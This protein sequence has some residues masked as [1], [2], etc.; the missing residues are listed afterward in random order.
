MSKMSQISAEMDEQNIP[1]E[2][3][4]TLIDRVSEGM[5]A[6]ERKIDNPTQNTNQPTRE[7]K[8][9]DIARKI[10]RFAENTHNVV[11]MDGKVYVKVG[12][13]QY[14]ADLLGITPKFSF[15]PESTSTEVWCS[16]TLKDEKG[17]VITTTVMY[18]DKREKFLCDK[19]DFAVLGTAQTR[20]FTRA[21]KNIYGFVVEMIGYQSTGFEEM[22]EIKRN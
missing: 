12:V 8:W 4:N 19:D 7:N 3:R 18:A 1:E 11:S 22:G 15:L 5:H 6:A 13:Y 10:K 2:K 14:L 9:G 17:D 20:A 21:M 16:C